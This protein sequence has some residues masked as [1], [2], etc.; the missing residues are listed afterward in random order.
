MSSPHT[1]CLILLTPPKHEL[2]HE[3]SRAGGKSEARMMI[4]VSCGGTH[5][6]NAQ[7]QGRV[8]R[9]PGRKSRG[10]KGC[11]AC[12]WVGLGGWQAGGRSTPASLRWPYEAA[13]LGR[14]TAARGWGRGAPC[15]VCREQA[16]T[17][18]NVEMIRVA[19]TGRQGGRVNGGLRATPGGKA[20]VAGACVGQSLG[21]RDAVSGMGGVH[22]GRERQGGRARKDGQTVERAG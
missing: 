2:Q 21:A 9:G 12:W 19:S 20:Q 11:G 5:S 18:A 1:A 8:R 7:R 14:S 6:G 17:S 3:H 13:L 10:K 22:G 4:A 16:R 15:S